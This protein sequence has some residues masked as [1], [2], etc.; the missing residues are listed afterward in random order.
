MVNFKENEELKMK[1]EEYAGLRP[2]VVGEGHVPPG[3]APA[4]ETGC[5]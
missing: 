4:Q 3:A 2:R 1:N 5:R